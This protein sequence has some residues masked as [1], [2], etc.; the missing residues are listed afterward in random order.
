MDGGSVENAGAFFNLANR[1]AMMS[2][3]HKPE[4][5]RPQAASYGFIKAFTQPLSVFRYFTLGVQF[6]TFVSQ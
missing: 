5:H 6:L 3:T 1:P 2:R 4:F